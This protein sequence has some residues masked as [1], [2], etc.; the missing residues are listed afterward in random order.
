MTATFDET[1][2]LIRREGED[3]RRAT[4]ADA[5]FYGREDEAR[6][7]LPITRGEFV[8]AVVAARASVGQFKPIYDRLAA[9]K[10]GCP[11]CPNKARCA[12]EGCPK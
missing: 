5:Y 10:W 8:A 4:Q 9:S 1:L 11:D 3:L 6:V 7:P 12:V 2:A